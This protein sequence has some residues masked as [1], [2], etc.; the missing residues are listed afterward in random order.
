[1]APGG[2]ELALDRV[3]QLLV[4]LEVAP[5]EVVHDQQV[6]AA[7]GQAGGRGD[8]LVEA[9]LEVGEFLPEPGEALAGRVPPTRSAIRSLRSGSLLSGVNATGVRAYE[10]SASSPLSVS[11]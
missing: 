4:Q 1:M 5:Q 3:D 6:L 2:G 10:L 9:L 8:G 7:V 11:R